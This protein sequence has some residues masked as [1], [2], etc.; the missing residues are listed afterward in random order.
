M[1]WLTLNKEPVLEPW[2]SVISGALAGAIS[3]AA[4]TPLDVV[5]TRM[6]TQ[7]RAIVTSSSGV[8]GIK[9]EAAA[10]AHAIANYTYTGVG[11]ALQQIC[12]EEGLSA[13]MTG[14]GPRMFYSASFSALGFCVF[15]F[16]RTFLLIRYIQEKNNNKMKTTNTITASL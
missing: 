5:K 3:A 15:E 4:T 10:R 7:A 13:L 14:I 9:A 1:G 6:M 16:S 2:Q 8:S 11:S 12:K